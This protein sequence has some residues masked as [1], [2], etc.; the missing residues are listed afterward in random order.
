MR[1]LPGIL[2]LTGAALVVI[3]ALLV[4]GLRI[5]LPHLDAWR[6]EILNKI[7]SATG[8]PVEAS[9]LSASWQNF[10][11]TL[12]AHDIRAELKDGGEFSV[13]RVTLALDVWQS[14]L[15]MRWQFRDLTFWQLRFRT[16]TPIT[17]GGS[18]D[19]LE[20]SHISDLFL[21]QF[22]HFDLRDSEVSFLTP[23]G[24]RAELAIPQLT[25]LNDPRRHRAEGLVSL[26][27]LTG[28]HGVM[29]V[30]MDLRDDEGLLSNGR[31]WL[32]ADDIDLKPWLGKWMQ[33]NIALETAQFSLEGWMTIDKGDVT[34][35]DV[36]L[37]QGGASWLG[38]KETHTLSVDNLT[39]HITRE[40][41]GWQFSIPD[42]RITMD[43]KPWPSGALTLAWIPEQD[44]GGKDNKRSDE[45]RIRASNLELAGLEGI[46]PLAAKLSPALGDVWRSTQ[47]SGKINTLALDIPLQAADKTRFQASWSDLA[48]KQWKLLPGAEH[49]SG[50]LSGSVEN[51]LLTASMKQAKMPYET[52]FR[53]PL[54]IA[55][56]QATISWLNNDKGF[57]LDGR[58]IDVKA[59][60]VHAR[61]GFRYLQPANDEPWLGILAGISTD[62]G[63]QAWRYFPENLM[64][65]DL[66]DYL[67]GAIQ[68]GEADNATLVYG[69]NPQLFPY[70]HNE[71]QFEVLVPLRNA[72]FAF[73][74]DW[75]A[76]T[77]LDIELDF[78]NDG[79]WMKTDGVNL[80]GVR[81]S[82]LTAVIPDYS[83][84]KLLIDADIK[85][86]GKAVGPYF[87]ETPL[88]DS[89]GATLQELQLD[90]DVN[91]R[92]HL[93]IPLNGELVTAKGEVT[94]RNNSLFIKPLDSTLKN[95]S[96]KFSFINGD[97]QSEPLTA[98]WFNQPLN[99][100][101]STKEG[102]K[103][104]QVAVN[105]NGNWQPAKTGVLPEAV[106]EALSGSVAWDGKVGIDLPYHAGATYN[107]EL[108]GDLKNVSSHLPSPLA[109][110]AGEPLPV[111]VKVDGNLNSFDLTGQAGADNHF[112]SR[113]L[114]GQKLTLDR[115][116]WAADSKTLPPLP[117]QSG[118]ELNMPPMNGAEWLALFQKGAAESVGGAASFPQH[119][120]LRTPMLSLGNQQWNNLSIVSQPTANGTQVEAQGREINATLAMRNNAPW[121][122]NIKYLYYNPSVAKTRGDSTPSS[123]F[124]TTERINFRGWPDAQIRCA[125]CWFWGQKFGRIDSDL[126]ISG[127]T[128][129][130]TNGLIDTGFSRL[131]ADG[132]WVNN[133]GN[134][135]TSLKGKLRGQKIDAAAEFFGVTTP[136]RQS[137]FNV[138]YDLHW[139]KAPWQPDEAT[140]NGIIHT[141][142]GKGEI[143]EINTG[144]AGQLLRLL[145]VDALMRKLRF[146]FRDTFGEGFYFDSI[147]STAWIKD[148]VM[149]TDDTLVDGLEADIAMK[150]S[151]NLVR[152]DLNMEAVVAPE[153]SATVGVAAAFAVNPIV[154]AAVFAASKV[155]GPLWSKVSILRYHISGPLDDPQINEVLRQPRKEKAQ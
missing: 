118:V 22:D 97:L 131:T 83:K 141:Q 25:W 50:T 9:Q 100:D 112:N 45:L 6:P 151:V 89:L 14:L 155:L 67:S 119:I 152:R 56:G 52:V 60:A 102:A 116:I 126:T 94:L 30:R 26:S 147:R 13:K 51:G 5:A 17:S 150:G 75:P 69:G 79:L 7:E 91:A 93:D 28:Q 70:K 64:G 77:N 113:W 138:D 16:N 62:D 99:V 109:K 153:I 120:T 129:T 29:Q 4:S 49:F 135:R 134:E 101:F 38:E 72:K 18:D 122:A 41:P 137:S 80:G 43:G 57:Q 71:G 3:A 115:A 139:R 132:E 127:D 105:L 46:R 66:V 68:G 44:V 35:G 125:E 90:G 85:G 114:L 74:P 42:T 40:N 142:L 98:S 124:P 73:Q 24:Q 104:Y 23:S 82:N 144:H 154:G 140:L 92:L 106:N 78:I 1:R 65:K 48:W 20:A 103:A 130:L 136:I 19:S 37:K 149:H 32:Q 76:L 58:N 108:N 121:L 95:L 86:P 31:V 27:S 54:E 36:W 128:L 47:P 84:E 10:G 145:S 123:P 117:E 96:G 15:H 133:P 33:D 61:G 143:T 8:M 21:R 148:G 146:D 12:E 111:N 39:A 53:A 110:P 63:S 11:P 87:D 81:A 59:K 55:D 34:G 2:L 88:K 107:V